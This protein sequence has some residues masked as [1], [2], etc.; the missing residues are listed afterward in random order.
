MIADCYSSYDYYEYWSDGTYATSYQLA[1]IRLPVV[2]CK[3]KSEIP[4]LPKHDWDVS[5]DKV[6]AQ[7]RPLPPCNVPEQKPSS[8]G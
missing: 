4:P 8:Y 7:N 2:D 5:R 1:Y 6:V 3:S